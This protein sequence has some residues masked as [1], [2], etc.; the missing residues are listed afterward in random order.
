MCQEVCE[1]ACTHDF[2][3]VIA[4]TFIKADFVVNDRCATIL[5]TLSPKEFDILSI[6]LRW[7]VEKVLRWIWSRVN[8]TA[9]DRSG[10]ERRT[11]Y[12][13]SST[14]SCDDWRTPSYGEWINNQRRNRYVTFPGGQN[15]L[16]ETIASCSIRQVRTAARLDLNQ[17]GSYIRASIVWCIPFD[18][19]VFIDYLSSWC[20]RCIRFLSS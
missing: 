3:C 6:R 14:K 1:I 11:C 7:V 2:K 20:K 4:K 15:W 12:D 16:N 17:I 5:C 9:L 8:D 19:Y 13:I 10:R 18:L